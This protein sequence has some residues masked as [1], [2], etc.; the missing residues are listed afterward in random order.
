MAIGGRRRSGG[1]GGAGA[2]RRRPEPIPTRG[3]SRPRW[4][5]AGAVAGVALASLGWFL[6][7]G[8]G[9]GT[10]ADPAVRAQ[11]ADAITAS[12]ETALEPLGPAAGADLLTAPAA[13]G[14]ALGM[15]TDDAGVVRAAATAEG[16]LALLGPARDAIAAIDV[17]AE[18]RD[19]GLDEAF[20]VDCI[21]A[22]QRTLDALDL[23]LS[24]ARLAVEAAVL[25]EPSLSVVLA[26]AR[27]LA[28]QAARTLREGHDLL[29]EVQVAAGTYE[30]PLVPAAAGLG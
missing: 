20:V 27:D 9:G 7:G 14:D 29:I 22:R 13:L 24:A 18:V 28:D 21:Q 1:R 26:T 15:A 8:P 10:E 3:S 17:A 25:E 19:R 2:P 30:G 4:V 12:F 6:V 16:L 23:Y 5:A 11:V